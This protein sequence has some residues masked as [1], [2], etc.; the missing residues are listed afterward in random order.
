MKNRTLEKVDNVIEK[1]CD[2]SCDR[3]EKINTDK[4]IA[5]TE[6]LGRILTARAA[7]TANVPVETDEVA[8]QI[9][10]KLEESLN[11]LNL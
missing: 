4:V 10:D 1:L 8:L 11:Y 7:V 6:A 2:V 9:A 5:L 3:I